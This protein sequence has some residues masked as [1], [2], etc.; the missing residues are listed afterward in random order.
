MEKTLLFICTLLI[1]HYLGAQDAEVDSL[2]VVIASSENDSN[3]VL[4]MS[5]L[6]QRL[7]QTDLEEAIEINKEGMQ[8]AEQ[9]GY[10]SGVS[11]AL[12]LLGIEYYFLGEYADALIHWQQAK[13]AFE[14]I[15]D[16]AGVANV[17]SNM[18]AIYHNQS[19]YPKAIEF[20]LQA[21]KL[22]EEVKDTHR[23]GTV[24]QNIGAVQIEKDE[25]DLAISS[26][27]KALPFFVARN[28][29]EGIGL[30]HLNLGEVY[31][32]KSSYDSATIELQE[33]VK[34]LEP[35]PYYPTLLR[36]L[37]E[38]ELKTTGFKE[39]LHYL[40]LA[41]TEADKMG[42][43]FE[44]ARI[45]NSIARAYEGHG[46]VEKALEY[47]EQGKSLL[48]VI[49]AS[50][51][52]L[53][54]SAGGLVRLYSQKGDYKRAY[55]S[56][57]VL[58]DAK[59]TLYNVESSNKINRLLFNFDLEKKEGEI[60]LL[61]KDKEIQEIEVEKQKEIRNG[62]IAG[63]I[64]VLIFGAFALF[65]R[66]KIKKG[67]K[68]SDELLLNILPAEVADELKEKGHADAQLIEHVTV[69]F[70]DFKGF[71]AMS[72]VLSPKDLVNDL[73][74]CFSEFDRI[75]GEH[76]IEKIKTIGDAYMAAGGL[77]TP[78]DTHA[79][80]VVK[81][82][83]KMRDFVEAGKARKIAA[84]LPFFEIRIGIH[85]GPVVAGI[86]GVK[87]FQYDIWGDTVNTASRMES[88]G[89]VGK[90]NISQATYELLMTERSRSQDTDA[91]AP[92]S[93]HNTFTFESRGKI[94]AKGKGEMEMWF[95]S[96]NS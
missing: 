9:I 29:G 70:T 18:G 15:G 11:A 44:R 79:E 57:K 31:T 96:V 92:L 95:V 24:L 5:E 33:A 67:K 26:F 3:K 16:D 69:L 58:Q 4:V 78:N 68:L 72:E 85:T 86:V 27:R 37:G 21:L 13:L 93:V 76:N 61:V 51:M 63:F 43:E 74:I 77:P 28:Y 59:D 42:D 38:V 80:D 56:Q 48:E 34:Y 50:S 20:Y 73:N 14:K 94:E 39:G 83:F 90:V 23:I 36:A 84:G 46:N 82:A 65:Q 41:Y 87:K 2:K 12:N 19:D 64:L 55:E 22:A 71:T 91:S 8:L 88:S 62:F 60:A 47:F 17:L 32:Y 1:S 30:A 81:A 54:I 45:I 89:E 66:N 10:A 49:D 25:Y 75:I 6:S 52:E 40:E 7:H 35:T 53:Q